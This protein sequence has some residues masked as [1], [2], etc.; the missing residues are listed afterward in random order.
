RVAPIS[1]AWKARLL[2][3]SSQAS[4]PSSQASFQK[5]CR[6]FT[7]STAPLELSTTFLP[8]LSTSAPPKSHRNGYANVGGSPKLW[9]RA[10]PTGL[11]LALSFLP[12]SRYSSHVF[13]NSLAPISLKSE[14]RYATALAPTPWGTDSHL[15][16]TFA[17][18]LN[19]S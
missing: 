8:D 17:D 5:A 12:T 19:T 18:A 3:V 15:P 9:P 13:G 6:N 7:D 1:P 4:P 2:L 11:P 14:R 16:P 10:W